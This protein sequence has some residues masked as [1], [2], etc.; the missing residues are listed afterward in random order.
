MGNCETCNRPKNYYPNNAQTQI[1]NQYKMDEIN[2]YLNKKVNKTIIEQDAIAGK[3][4]PISSGKEEEINNQMKNSICKIYANEKYGTAFL[5]KIPFPDE[6]S[7][8]PVLIANKSLINE[9]Y[10]LTKRKIDIIFD[11]DKEERTIIISS[12]RKIYSCKN[13]DIIFIEIFPKEDEINNTQ[14]LEVYMQMPGNIKYDIN[15]INNQKK[16]IIIFI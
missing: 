6:F 13:Y 2:T 11:N 7:F 14:F 8:L 16:I 4:L 15:D 9:D 1:A 3:V 12:E 5:C 10:L